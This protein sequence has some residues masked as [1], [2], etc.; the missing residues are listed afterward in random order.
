[1]TVCAWFLTTSKNFRNLAGA[2]IAIPLASSQRAADT[3][4]CYRVCCFA[5]SDSFCLPKI[6]LLGSNI[7]QGSAR[8]QLIEA[9]HSFC[10]CVT[11]DGQDIRVKKWPSIFEVA[12]CHCT[13]VDSDLVSNSSDAN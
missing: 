2:L 9:T 8:F 4:V 3:V 12:L 1:M 11:S 10:E 6:Q 13:I 7:D 5:T